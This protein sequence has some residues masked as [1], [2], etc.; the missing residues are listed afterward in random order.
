[1]KHNAS[2]INY[3]ADDIQRYI[4]GKMLPT[5][6]HMLEK[7]ALDDPFLS[8]AIE[9]YQGL[10]SHEWSTAVADLKTAF[11]ARHQ[12]PAPVVRLRQRRYG[13]VR[14]AAAVLV[15]GSAIAAAYWFNRPTSGDKS[16]PSIAAVETTPAPAAATVQPLHDSAAVPSLAKTNDS[17]VAVGNANTLY[18]TTDLPP[19]RSTQA[20]T[21]F[22]DQLQKT[23]SNILAI[24]TVPRVVPLNELAPTTAPQSSADRKNYSFNRLP[25][26]AAP[27]ERTDLASIGEKKELGRNGNEIA[28]QNNNARNQNGFYNQQTLNNAPG[29]LRTNT[30]SNIRNNAAAPVDRNFVA[31]VVDANNNPLPFANISVKSEGLDTYADAKGNVRLVSSDSLIPIEV[32]SLGFE[33]RAF[34]LRSSDKPFGSLKKTNPI[35]RKNR[36]PR[37]RAKAMW[38]P[39]GPSCKGMYRKM[40]NRRMVG[41]NTILISPITSSSPM[42]W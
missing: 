17:T 36:L 18:A 25:V 10:P 37:K 4:E 34:V 5:E 9:G 35:T 23:D 26:T 22:N 42:I 33:S 39:A 28:Q 3:T 2:H 14:Y 20:P 38:Y 41:T 12:A 15:V 1:M 32:K 8:E 29:I 19:N 6:M 16:T 30:P 27:T 24:N 40:R 11:A 21:S 7:A 13:W 31:Q